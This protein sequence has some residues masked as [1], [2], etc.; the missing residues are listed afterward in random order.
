[1]LVFDQKA[2]AHVE[3][4]G[5]ECS[6]H[7][8]ALKWLSRAGPCYS[9]S[10]LIDYM[11]ELTLDRLD[12]DRGDVLRMR[13]LREVLSFNASTNEYNEPELQCRSSDTNCR[14]CAT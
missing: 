9:Y 13:N 14:K 11:A 3:V 12:C 8:N 7:L 4:R 1:M 2:S 5:I 6:E 10:L